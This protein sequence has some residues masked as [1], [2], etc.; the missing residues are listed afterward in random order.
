MSV[1]LASV[2]PA[3][4]AARASVQCHMLAARQACEAVGPPAGVLRVGARGPC[5]VPRPRAHVTSR[6]S[7]GLPDD[8]QSAAA[9][10]G[11]MPTLAKGSGYR[12]GFRQVG[13]QVSFVASGETLGIRPRPNQA[14]LMVLRKCPI[15]DM[16]TFG[17]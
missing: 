3:T 1:A 9:E 12:Y 13:L 17:H 15:P 6:E 5:R 7:P 10:S 4:D 16:S 14:I 11:A 8:D 2:V